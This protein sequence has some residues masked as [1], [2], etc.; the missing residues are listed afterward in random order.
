MKKKKIKNGRPS[1]RA[2]LSKNIQRNRIAG[3]VF[4]SEQ[5]LEWLID[6]VEIVDTDFLGDLVRQTRLE[7]AKFTEFT[8]GV[9]ATVRV[10]AGGQV[11]HN[12]GN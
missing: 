12:S 7:V 8:L 1:P 9:E 5:T 6:V 11:P 10:T 2:H 4:F 3:Q